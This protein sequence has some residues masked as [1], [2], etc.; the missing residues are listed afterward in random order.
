MTELIKTEGSMVT[1]P[2]RDSDEIDAELPELGP[3]DPYPPE[4]EQECAVS[5]ELTEVDG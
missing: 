1:A 5:L 3:T 2:E 4:S